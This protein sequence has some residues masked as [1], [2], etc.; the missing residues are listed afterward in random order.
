MRLLLRLAGLF[1]RDKISADLDEEFAYHLAMREELNQQGG[2]P[3]PEARSAA[4]R[5]FGNITRLKESTREQNLL[6][7]VETVLQDIRFAASGK[8]GS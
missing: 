4:Q 3:L 8:A 7:F 5:S 1:R 6:V 2:M